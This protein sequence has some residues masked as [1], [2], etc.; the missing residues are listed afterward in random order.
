MFKTDGNADW[1]LRAMWAL[2][3]SGGWTSDELVGALSDPDEHIR[4]WA[5]QL[6]CEDR[7]PAPQAIEIFARLARDERSA[8]VR[9][10]LAAA[11]QRLDHGARWNIASALLTHAEDATDQNLPTMIWLGVEPLVA[12]NPALA[13]ERA[14]G[15]SIPMVARYVARRTVDA[16][17]LEPLVAAVG[18]PSKMHASLLEGMRDGLEGRVDLVPPASW[19][20][21]LARLSRSSDVRVARL[22]VEVSE[23][24]GDTESARRNLTAVRTAASPIEV[25]RK[26][27]Q[28]LA[29]QRRPELV[30]ELRTA[31]DDPALRV[32]AIRAIAAFDD[33]GLG[34]LLIARYPS[35]SGAEKAEAIQTL[36]SRG[37]YGRMLTEALATDVIPKRDVPPYVAR[38]L[39]RVVGVRFAEVWGPVEVAAAEERAYARY[40]GL[41]NDKAMSG[42]NAASG[43]SVFQRTCGPC[44]KMY[45]EGGPIG[46][47]ITGSNRA[48]L[49]YVLL[50][51]LNPNAEVQDAY[52][53]VVVTTRDGRSRAGN[54]IA[55]TDRQ[56]TLR[57]VGGDPVAIAK[58]D[59]QSRESTTTSMMPPGLF[60]ALTDRE[61][62]DLVAYL[63][64]VEQVKVP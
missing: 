47:D 53:M 41:L 36:A 37:R 58:A 34:K 42:A 12:E 18:K 16:D 63:R 57:V 33:D 5:I 56:I 25:R 1:R 29:A 59:I 60:D 22:A 11:L 39:R 14:S 43:R 6:L 35:F 64:T 13:L 31:M 27:L 55:E 48:N 9:L 62:I 46:P 10:Y 7:S 23:Q 44:H 50:N 45:G 8:V 26:A 15:G 20:P 24:F 51:V 21:T 49:E 4:A 30:P 61:V 2:H 28:T 38:Q 32:D 3:V 52:K 40:R 19:A 54:V 17:A